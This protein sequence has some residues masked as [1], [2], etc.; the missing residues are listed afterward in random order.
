MSKLK[1]FPENVSVS[2]AS[3]LAY[4]LIT[5]LFIPFLVNLLFLNVQF[6]NI[7]KDRSSF[8]LIGL[9]IYGGWLTF[10]FFLYRKDCIQLKDLTITRQKFTSGLVAALYVFIIVNFILFTVLLINKNKVAISKDF[11]SISLTV[12]TLGLF[13]FNILIGAFIEEVIFRA[14]LIPQVFYRVKNKVGNSIICLIITIL[15]TQALFAISHISRDLFR[16][17][18][19]FQIITNDFKSLFGSGVILSLIFL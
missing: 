3:I 8:V 17:N 11:S 9:L 5:S 14:Y 7:L 1:P 13:I 12:Q 6:A 4:V 19:D 2:K 15:I 10:L 18:Y 16:N